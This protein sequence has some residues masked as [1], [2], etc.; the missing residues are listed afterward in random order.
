MKNKKLKSF[1]V[2]FG[3]ILMLSSLYIKY[4]L[5]YIHIEKTITNT[6]ISA[7]VNH[8]IDESFDDFSKKNVRFKNTGDIDAFIRVS[9][10]V[11]WIDENGDISVDIPV[12]DTDYSMVFNLAADGFYKDGYFYF[13]KPV[14]SG[15]FTDFFIKEATILGRKNGYRLQIQIASNSVQANPSSAV[16]EAWGIDVVDSKLIKGE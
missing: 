13:R 7:N 3:I 14:K 8:I 1:L 4:A 16:K 5:A 9:Y 15:E 10:A 2:L 12:L 6:F 11:N